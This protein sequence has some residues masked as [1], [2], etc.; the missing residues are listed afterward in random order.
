MNMSDLSGLAQI[1]ALM[2]SGH[3]SGIVETLDLRLVEVDDGRAVF[4]GTP[5]IRAYNPI[6][7]VHGGYA[8]TLLDSACG[9]AVHSKLFP[10]QA[11]TTLEIKIAYHRAMTA[12]TGLVRAEGTVLSFGRR[13]AFAEARLTDTAGRIL[14]SATSSLL[15]F[16][17]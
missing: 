15:V 7:T 8:A 4:E 16:Q 5:G 3:R 12:E 14:A 1:R 11:Y 2:L 6:G 17:R 10:D 9:I 13:A